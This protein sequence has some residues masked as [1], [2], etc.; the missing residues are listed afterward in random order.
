MR[1]TSEALS[2][3]EHKR[4]QRL[5]AAPAPASTRVTAAALSR[6]VNVGPRS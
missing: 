5:G 4:K 3:Q 1:E 2:K 6:T